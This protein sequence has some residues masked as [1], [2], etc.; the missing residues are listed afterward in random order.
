MISYLRR[1][2]QSFRLKIKG[3]SPPLENYKVV[4]NQKYSFNG[5]H[6][7]YKLHKRIDIHF[8][9]N[10]SLNFPISIVF[11]KLKIIFLSAKI[12]RHC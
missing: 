2:C 5:H 1:E 9:R 6:S 7:D 10:L 12:L 11:P 8:E 3:S 4:F